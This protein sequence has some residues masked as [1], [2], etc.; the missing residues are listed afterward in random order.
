[1][2]TQNTAASKIQNAARNRKA[3]KEVLKKADEYLL[4]TSAAS[5]IQDDVEQKANKISIQSTKILTI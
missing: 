5:K 2:R 4:K 1:M 3:R